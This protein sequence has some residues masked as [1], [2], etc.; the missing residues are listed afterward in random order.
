MKPLP[1]PK[2]ANV[3][4]SDTEGGAT[5]LLLLLVLAFALTIG[6]SISVKGRTASTSSVLENMQP[7]LINKWILGY[8]WFSLG[9]L[10]ILVF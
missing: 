6:V 10:F 8:I 2:Q 9:L 4:I 1:A 5:Y 7:I 3:D